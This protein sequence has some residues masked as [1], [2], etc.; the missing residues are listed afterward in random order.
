MEFL[1]KLG[2]SGKPFLARAAE[3]KSR[4]KM[5]VEGL[6]LGTL[7]SSVASVERQHLAGPGGGG[8]T[9]S[10]L[11]QLKQAMSKM[12]AR[13]RKVE[14]EMRKAHQIMCKMVELV[15][16]DNP[17]VNQSVRAIVK[18]GWDS[19]HWQKG[20]TCLH[21]AAECMDAPGV[22]ELLA[23]LA[24]DMNEKDE[25]G[26][27]PLDYARKENRT[28]NIEVL[29]RLR[30]QLYRQQQAEKAMKKK[31]EGQMPEIELPDDLTPTLRAGM[32][33]VL[34]MGW[35]KIKWPNGFSTLHL[36][37]QSGNVEVIQI[38]LERVPDVKDDYQT[39]DKLGNSPLDYAVSSN[40]EECA[41]YLRDFDPATVVYPEP[42]ESESILSGQKKDVKRDALKT[43]TKRTGGTAL[44]G[45]AAV[46]A[47]SVGAPEKS[48]QK[49]PVL[50]TEIPAG[51]TDSKLKEMLQ[52]V[53]DGGYKSPN[54]ISWE[55][56][57]SPMHVA[58]ELA[59]EA[60]CVF[61][62]GFGAA[63]DRKNDAGQTPMEVA[64]AK[65]EKNVAVIKKFVVVADGSGDMVKE[66]VQLKHE[67]DQA[68]DF[69]EQN[70]GTLDSLELFRGKTVQLQERVKFLQ[71]WINGISVEDIGPLQ[72][73][74]V[75]TY[76]KQLQVVGEKRLM[77]KLMENRMVGGLDLEE[78]DAALAVE[79]L[80]FRDGKG[81]ADG[82][83]E[84]L[85]HGRLGAAGS[86]G[87]WAGPPAAEAAAAAAPVSAVGGKK[88]SAPP[89]PGGKGGAPPVPGGKGGAP[90]VPGGKGG[91]PV[92]GGKGG[93][94]PVPGGKGGAPPVPG[95]GG[96]PGVPGKGGAP[97]VPGGK[98]G[99]PGKP[100]PPAKGGAAGPPAKGGAAVSKGGKKGAAKGGGAVSD[101]KRPHIKPPKPMK[102]LWWTKIEIGKGGV[103]PG[104]TIW[105][106]VVDYNLKLLCIGGPLE[107][108][109]LNRFSKTAMITKPKAAGAADK[110]PEGPKD[111][112]VI[113]DPGKVV[114]REGAC[115]NYPSPEI[116]VEALVHFDSSVINK[117][118]LESIKLNIT[119]T[120]EELAQMGKL[121]SDNPNVPW[122]LIEKYMWA[123]AQVPIYQAR[124]DIWNFCM[125]FDERAEQIKGA[126]SEMIKVFGALGAAKSLKAIF[127]LGLALGNYMN[128]NTNRGQ[129]DGFELADIAKFDGIKD[130]SND[131]LKATDWMF[132]EFLM[133][134][135]GGRTRP[136]TA[137][138]SI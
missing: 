94:P 14:S 37:A 110:K 78:M 1:K 61:L 95:K 3:D 9:R 60:A 111:L 72:A 119:P 50:P 100:G 23:L 67:L 70:H 79:Q 31:A 24:K 17:L 85:R 108:D 27:R 32:E 102:P 103:N 93:A 81:A 87:A 25:T 137:R 73:D 44:P 116:F 133:G 99:V 69:I 82:I 26:K 43:Q 97:A 29:E 47:E 138:R 41:Q 90:P 92:P 39:K 7:S 30:N 122:G 84:Q 19:I 68:N 123:I 98:P 106:D 124:I 126:Y 40:Q 34:H 28:G 66:L 109:V 125:T 131:K 113:T 22:V 132:R 38:L 112:R 130:G 20:Y 42:G 117:D 33:A 21:F 36:A 59:S 54:T 101:S 64:Q 86:G 53:L 57:H 118:L 12:D 136:A 77:K 80:L 11:A 56:G 71:Q 135:S 104:D 114:G 51:V 5:L 48:K 107:E 88:G 2:P 121:R 45:M 105:D 52:Q 35:R 128:G 4:Q 89:V 134:R 75:D 18:Y 127:G 6:L 83:D 49:G 65:G 120:P 58:A 8:S 76:S 63:F 10:Q 46:A 16:V 129:A 115:K 96:A 13:R 74:Q 55:G 62:Q 15:D 91:P